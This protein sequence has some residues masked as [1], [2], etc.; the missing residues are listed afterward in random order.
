MIQQMKREIL[1]EGVETQTQIDMLRK[2]GVDYLQG[3]FFSQPVPVQEF[4]RLISDGKERYPEPQPA[5]VPQEDAEP[6]EAAAS[7]ETAEPQ[8]NKEPEGN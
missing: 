3:Y 4:V 6:Q 1:V 5:E 2:L 7:Q 8:E